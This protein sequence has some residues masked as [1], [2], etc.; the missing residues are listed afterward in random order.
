MLAVLQETHWNISAAAERLGLTRNTLRYRMERYRVRAAR[1]AGVS[2]PV[3]RPPAPE[4]PEPVEAEGT[5]WERRPVTFLGVTLVA[6]PDTPAAE[7]GSAVEEL[8][9][10]IASFGGRVMD[11]E[12]TSVEAVFGL[13][14]VDDAPL[15]AAH[16]ALALQRATERARWD[17]LRPFAVKVALHTATVPVA[18]AGATAELDPEARRVV[19][20]V[21]AALLDHAEP[22]RVLLTAATAPLLERRLDLIRVGPLE[23][24]PGPI[25][26]LV[27]RERMD[28]GPGRRLATFVGRRHDVELLQSRLRSAIAGHGQV[29]GIA[30]EAGIGKSRLLYEFRQTLGEDVRYLEGRCLSY[31]SGIPYLPLLDIL[32]D[33]CGILE[34][35]GPKAIVDKV[36]RG[37]EEVGMDPAEGAPYLLQLLGIRDGTD[38]LAVLSPEAIKART[39]E[40]QRQLGLKG[41]RRRPLVLAIENVHW[42]DRTSDEYLAAFVESLAGAPILLILTY[43][44]GYRPAGIEKSYATQI[45]LQPL[46]AADGASIV[47][48]VRQAE[49]LPE[50]LTDAIVARAE[51]NPLFLEELALAVADRGDGAAA[52][53]IPGT[54]QEVLLA[55]I[56]R[57][58]EECRPVL[59]AAAVLGR[60][61]SLRLLGEL[62]QGPGG[63]EPHLAELRRLE[64]LYEESGAQEPVYVFRHALTQEVAYQSLAP[65]RRR[66]LHARAARALEAQYADRL[67]EVYDRVAHHYTR[68]EEATRAIHYLVRSAEKSAR[69]YAHT[70]AVGALQAALG[71]VQQLAP[72]ERDRIRLDLA[73][74]Q[75]HSL[76]FLGRFADSLALLADLRETV[77]GLRD[78]TLASAYHFWLAHTHSHLGQHQAAIAEAER[79]LAEATQAGDVPTLGKAHY[80]LARSG[81]WGGQL[82]E[83]VTQGQQAIALLEGTAERWWLGLAH[84]GLAFGRGF[85]GEVGPAFQAAARADALGHEI[86][87]PRL[88][89]YA[90][91]TTGWLHAALGDSDAAVAACRRSLE[92]SPDPVNTA[93][94]MSFLGYVLLERGDVGEATGLLEQSV[95]QWRAFGHTPMLAWFTTVL[96]EAYLAAG[97]TGR[98]H[99]AASRGLSLAREAA[100]PYGLGLAVRALGRLARARGLRDEA[101]R[102]LGEALDTFRTIDARYEQ[103]RTCLD[104]AALAAARD[105]AGARQAHLAE[106]RRLFQALGI[107]RDISDPA[108]A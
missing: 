78:P 40:T 75:A 90:A 10:K 97:D 27:G 32:R 36:R 57:L 43:R 2:E 46:S 33:H 107:P 58:S 20:P 108:P 77:Q 67:A 68:A 44:P 7:A 13:D 66:V 9:D 42:I 81:F 45:A 88:Q 62:W 26:R 19:A 101:A 86:G 84:W 49:K 6:P 28:P 83:S 69:S 50:P 92:R 34:T 89:T 25:A 47:R 18:G 24:V 29:V 70:E 56:Q 39:F 23:G 38:R 65:G 12:G 22:G 61:F 53:R 3:G 94:A 48:F 74:R 17:D 1:P 16:A 4:P 82:H 96:A 95:A 106:A 55:R 64:F 8:L 100:F 15:R 5:A 71:F 72:G 30:G 91:W 21:L 85:L 99:E 14:G 35:D 11:R 103:A 93:D 37:L 73:L 31:G 79:A 60:E 51:G 63:L 102:L 54:L 87:D 52:M 104:L 59:Q 105:D 41:S 76:Y 80:V 98:A